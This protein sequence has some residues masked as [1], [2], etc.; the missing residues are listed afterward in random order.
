MSQPK[1]PSGRHRRSRQ[2]ATVALSIPVAMSIACAGVA[3]A[4]PTQPGVAVEEAQPGVADRTNEQPGTTA[5]APAPQREYL[6]GYT[7]IY[8][9]APSKPVPNYDYDYDYG[10]DYTDYSGPATTESAPAV[11]DTAGPDVITV[12]EAPEKKFRAG[13]YIADQTDL[14]PERQWD[15]LNATLADVEAGY[16]EVWKA[17]GMVDEDE[18]AR[19]SAAAIGTGALGAA[20]GAAVGATG[21]ALLGGTIGGI[22]GAALGTLVPLPPPLPQVTSGVVGT[23]GGA[24]I[25]GTAGA[26][27]GGVTG[28]L[29]GAGIGTVFGAGEEPEAPIEFELPG[30]VLSD[31]T[32]PDA[33][34]DIA[35]AQEPAPSAS[36]SAAEQA[37]TTNAPQQ[38]TQAYQDVRTVVA[39]QPGGADAV[40]GFEAAVS[41][42]SAWTE[43]SDPLAEATAALTAM[44]PA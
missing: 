10:T 38:Y 43:A 17:T 3:T 26:V 27:A 24:V 39:A 9:D 15:Q 31:Q 11:P 23:A 22:G 4:A 13:T 12:I 20:G 36:E 32:E 33:P 7:P 2:R 37:T 34:T 8:P 5:P 19:I 21:G 42:V 28:G 40:A 44:L 35:A 29:V 41:E 18:A 14:L 30:N 1:N 16:G 6:P 25:G